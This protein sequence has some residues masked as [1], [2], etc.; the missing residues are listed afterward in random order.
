[1]DFD[2]D[3]WSALALIAVSSGVFLQVVLWIPNPLIKITWPT[4]LFILPLSIALLAFGAWRLR[5]K[6]TGSFERS[7]YEPAIHPFDSFGQVDRIKKLEASLATFEH[8]CLQ[9]LADLKTRVEKLENVPYGT[10]LQESQSTE[11]ETVQPSEVAE[12][13]AKEVLVAE[14]PEPFSL[15]GWLREVAQTK[16][17]R[18]PIEEEQPN[19][20]GD[21]VNES[22][23]EGANKIAE[24]ASLDAAAP[25]ESPQLEKPTKEQLTALKQRLHIDKGSL[26]F[27]D[28]SVYLVTSNKETMK[29]EWKRLGRWRDLAVSLTAPR[30]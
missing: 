24:P 16:P 17:V 14:K 11:E 6:I 22:L 21:V 15:K 19:S 1:M 2:F 13:P 3:V 30:T 20:P 25:L 4:Q 23:E 7:L 10:A 28:G 29:H 26:Q 18:E 5:E 12:S 27:K 9:D 8:V